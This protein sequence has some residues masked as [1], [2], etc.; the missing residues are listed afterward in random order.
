MYWS[1]TDFTFCFEHL[2]LILLLLRVCFVRCYFCEIVS[3]RHLFKTFVSSDHVTPH[4]CLWLLCWSRE[5]G[6]KEAHRLNGKH[7]HRSI[8]YDVTSCSNKKQVHF[9]IKQK[10]LLFYILFNSHQS[11]MSS[12]GVVS[13]QWAWSAE[14]GED[15]T[16]GEQV[17]VWGQRGGAV[18]VEAT[19]LLQTGAAL[20]ERTC[21]H[22]IVRHLSC[23]IIRPHPHHLSCDIIQVSVYLWSRLH[24]CSSG[25]RHRFL[26][27]DKSN[28]PRHTRSLREESV[29]LL[30]IR[31]IIDNIRSGSV[32][33]V[34]L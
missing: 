3:N 13:G 19:V 12:V 18:T 17:K 11:V 16:E 29:W 28:S 33:Q 31:H 30:I 6:N 9:S 27:S 34:F 21:T 5:E 24:K 1:Q 23:D 2:C 10:A 20:T 14:G 7:L 22:D 25:S 32:T 26:R 15:Q 4:V 8:K